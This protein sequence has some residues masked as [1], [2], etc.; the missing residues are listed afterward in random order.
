[1]RQWSWPLLWVRKGRRRNPVYD[2]S[3]LFPSERLGHLP[4]SAWAGGALQWVSVEGA[5]I[6]AARAGQ[7]SMSDSHQKPRVKLGNVESS[8]AGLLGQWSPTPRARAKHKLGD[9]GSLPL[10]LWAS[11]NLI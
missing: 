8:I 4:L 10:L 6:A 11:P 9:A 7:G 5:R 3:P 2:F 1:M